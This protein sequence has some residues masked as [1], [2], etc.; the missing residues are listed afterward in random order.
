MCSWTPEDLGTG[1]K[2]HP[3]SPSCHLEW[4]TQGEIMNDLANCCVLHRQV[5]VGSHDSYLPANNY[6]TLIAIQNQTYKQTIY[7]SRRGGR[8]KISKPAFL[9]VLPRGELYNLSEFYHFTTTLRNDGL[10]SKKN[11]FCQV[12]GAS[13]QQGVHMAS[14]T[15]HP[16]TSL[17]DFTQYQMEFVHSLECFDSHPTTIYWR[18]SVSQLGQHAEATLCVGWAGC[19]SL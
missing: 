18:W 11:A 1:P 10:R 17:F 16:W 7:H 8:N 14:S 13:F 3:D 12:T 9:R 15:P 2:K 19:V 5:L 4:V 6:L